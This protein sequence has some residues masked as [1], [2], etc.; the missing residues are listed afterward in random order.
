MKRRQQIQVLACLLSLV[1]LLAACG[2]TAP[3]ASQSA[4]SNAKTIKNGV[5]TIGL[6]DNYPPMEFRD[7]KNELVGFDVDLAKAIGEKMGVTVEFSPIAWEGIFEALKT[8]RYDVIMS[9]VSLTPERLENFSFTKPY[10]ANGQVIVAKP[11]D[12]TIKGPEDLAGFKV[13]VQ[14]NT[15]ADTACVKYN[16]EKGIDFE[17]TRYDDIIQTFEAMN[18]GRIDYIVV[19][20]AVAIDY[21]TKHPDKYYITGAQLTNEPIAVCLKKENTELRDQIQ[22]ALDEIRAEGKL[23]ELSKKWFKEDYTANIDET[24]Y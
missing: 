2:G 4:A 18:T 3:A 9:A 23:A 19:D 10:L 15:T 13:G 7:E 1:F 11:G 22:K 6:D 20:Y 14:T 16:K 17:L 8:D 21:Q 5:L 24:L 12:T